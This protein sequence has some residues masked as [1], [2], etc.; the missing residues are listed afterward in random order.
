MRRN[1]KSGLV[2]AALAA[3]LGTTGC[4]GS[5]VQNGPEY[6]RIE[7]KINALPVPD[8]AFAV[9]L[10]R[11]LRDGRPSAE[12]L[13]RLAGVVRRQLTHAEQRFATNHDA[14]AAQSVFGALFLVRAGEDRSDMIDASGDKAL[15]GTVSRVSARGDEGRAEVLMKMRAALLAPGSPARADVDAHLATLEQWTKDTRTGGPMQ[16]L[17][18]EQRTAAARAMVDPSDRALKAGVVAVTA[19]IKRGTE[20]LAEIERTNNMGDRDETIEALRAVASGGAVL[21]ALYVRHGNARGALEALEQTGIAHVHEALPEKMQ[22]PLADFYARLQD[23]AQGDGAREWTLLAAAFA[24][25]IPPDRRV[26]IDDD[27]RTAGVFC[28]SLEAYRRD[29]RDLDA[30]VFLSR[31]LAYFGMPEAA[32]LVLG[33]A[34]QAHP[35]PSTASA[36]ME[37]VLAA[38]SDSAEN[39]DV[40]T[41]RRTFAAGAGVL[42]L[43]AAPTLAGRVEPSPSRAR[44]IMA[45]IEL[46]SGNPGAARALLQEAVKGEPSVARYTTLAMVERQS[47]NAAGA[48]AA[49]E[50]A[51][52]APDA[53][54]ALLEVAEAHLLA[55]EISRDGGAPDRAKGSLDAALATALSARKMR[56]N[57]AAQARAE[58]ILGRVLEGYG[59]TKGATRAFDRALSLAASDRPQLAAAMLDAI[60]RALVRRDLAAARAALKRGIEGDVSEEDLVYGSLW[61]SLLE[62]QLKVAPDGTV[63]RALRPGG[64]SPWT[65]KLTAWLGG[66]INDNDLNTAA[67]NPSQRVEAAFYT[68]MA[69]RVAGDPSADQR[70][71]AVA[72]SPVIDLLEVR[73]ARDLVAPAVRADLPGGVQLP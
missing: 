26:Q 44:Y 10:H 68:A 61:V 2:V 22:R 41:A 70:L 39:E 29:P 28:A 32:P 7:G 19:W 17:A 45:S 60:G 67:Q 31:S 24:H 47:G 13:G 69:R 43:A 23:A 35:G 8:D 59:E 50:Q 12:R 3:S 15:A 36:A 11:I 73:I 38:V 56:G 33:E 57:A 40:E 14:R 66:K 46:R 18:A 53:R 42:T 27:L 52:R 9:E 54:V 51:L 62:R 71:K 48:S 5:E 65:A 16:R 6:P 34:L 49:I 20:H 37:L 55:Y 25:Q 1:V 63:E 30:A 72:S 21:A 64:K 4:L 58:R